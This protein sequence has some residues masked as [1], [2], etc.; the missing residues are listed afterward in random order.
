MAIDEETHRLM[1]NWAA[2]QS[3]ASISLAL[4]GAYALEARGR[5]AEMCMP[6]LNGEALDVDRAVEQ[7]DL[8]LHQVIREQW[9]RG[10]TAVQKAR[11]CRCHVDTFYK[12]L[13]VAHAHIRSYL[14]ERER[15][16]QLQRARYKKIADQARPRELVPR[17]VVPTVM[18]A[19]IEHALMFDGAGD[20]T[21][22]CVQTRLQASE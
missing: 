18:L 16:A 6:L 13:D 4:S 20:D 7:L 22:G 17:A 11:A 10:G 19:S 3:G 14:A 12:R 9:L 5:R 21:A 8:S 1:S 15:A 2:W